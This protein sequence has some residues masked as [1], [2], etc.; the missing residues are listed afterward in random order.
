VQGARLE[1]VPTV[2]HQVMQEAP[3]VLVDSLER[4]SSNLPRGR[5][6]V[7]AVDEDAV[8]EAAV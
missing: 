5:S 4:F 1:V 7:D 6:A 3:D 8:P 2:G